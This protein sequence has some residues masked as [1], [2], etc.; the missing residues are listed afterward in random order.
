M[1]TAYFQTKTLEFIPDLLLLHLLF[2]ERYPHL[3]A[4]A[5]RGNDAARYD[6]LFACPQQTISGNNFLELLDAEYNQYKENTCATDLPF[7]GGWFLYLGYELSQQVEPYPDFR[8][9]TGRFRH[10]LSGSYYH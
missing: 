9:N 5:A 10:S 2:P 1:G 4:S 7:Y 6:I 3:F 8:R